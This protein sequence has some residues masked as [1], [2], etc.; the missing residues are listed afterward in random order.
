MKHFFIPD[1]L[2]AKLNNSLGIY[3]ILTSCK[4]FSPGVNGVSNGFDSGN[5]QHLPG[6][7]K[8]VDMGIVTAPNK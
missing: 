5:G 8:G 4:Y 7:F 2:I 6:S 3:Y 1:A